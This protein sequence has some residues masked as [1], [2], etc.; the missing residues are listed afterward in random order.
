[1]VEL[2]V[3]LTLIGILIGGWLLIDDDR[4]AR[5]QLELAAN[6]VA[7]ALRFAQSQT[8]ATNQGHGVA[9]DKAAQNLRVYRLDPDALP[10][11]VRL[12]DVNHPVDLTPYKVSFSNDRFAARLETSDLFYVYR[13]EPLEMIEFLPGDGSPVLNEAGVNLYFNYSNI[14]LALEDKTIAVVVTPITARVIIQ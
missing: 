1:M 9:L 13:A 4:T 6:E 11:P 10:T 5:P 2:L 12:Y 7:M 14:Q 3:A 8:L